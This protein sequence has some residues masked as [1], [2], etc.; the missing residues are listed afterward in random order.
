MSW[1]IFDIVERIKT[2]SQKQELRLAEAIAIDDVVAVKKLLQQGVNPDLKI[3]GRVSEALIFLT[4]EKNWF[5]LPQGLIG[6]RLKTLYNVIAKEEC[7]HYLLEYGANPNVRDSLGR[8]PL[9][10]A[11]L[12]CLPKVVKLLLLHGADPNLRDSHGITPLMK[13]AIL[14]IQDARPMKDKLQIIFHLIDSGAEINAQAPDGKTALMYAT[15]NARI[16]IVELLVSSGASLSIT[17]HQ[18]NKAADIISRGISQQG[19]NYLHKILSQPQLNLIKYK[20]QEF[21]PEGDRLLKN[22]LN[23][24]LIKNIDSKSK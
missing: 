17:D 9:E 4:F 21:I 19:R 5:T 16:E 2:Y 7:L 24:Q 20:Y 6:D 15:G 22:I 3:V 1:V 14:G 23:N 12:W 8:T 18:G 13:T 11:I 10:I